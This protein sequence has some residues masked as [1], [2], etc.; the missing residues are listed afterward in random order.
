[1]ERADQRAL[2]GEDW[3]VELVKTVKNGLTITLYNSITKGHN[4]VTEYPDGRVAVT[5]VSGSDASK[6]AMVD[7]RNQEN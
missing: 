6:Q 1:L 4:I 3:G 2:L 5:K 7:I